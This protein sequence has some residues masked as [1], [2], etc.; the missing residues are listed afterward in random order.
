MKNVSK[1]ALF[2]AAGM[3]TAGAQAATIE[4]AEGTSME[5]EGAFTSDYLLRDTVD[6][7]VTGEKDN[8][9]DLAG[10]I[11]LS[12]SAV[13]SFD[14][15]DAY[16]EAAFLFANQ[17]TGGTGTEFDG[18]VAGLEGDF[19]QIEVG[20]TDSVYEDLITDSVDIT[21]EAGLSYGTYGFDENNMLT[22]Y[23]PETAGFSFRLQ[24]GIEDEVEGTADQSDQ[25]FIASA[26]YDFGAGAI[27]V[28]YDERGDT[29]GSDDSL[30]GIAAIFEV[31]MAEVSL[32]HEMETDASDQDTDYTGLAISYGY[33]AGKLYGAF[34]SESPDVG[35][36]K[37]QYAFGISA[38]LEDGINVYAEYADFDGQTGSDKDT[39]VAVGLAYEF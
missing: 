31:G 15:F 17:E 18:A 27:H 38:E 20:H 26:A 28:G 33:G 9:D 37:S 1:L 14:N 24:L 30:T 7:S 36:D 21:E 19:G 23:S 12:W 10:E 5:I 34:Q 2:V 3:M 11:E 25:G 29:A 13:R 35:E 22:Y 6:T 8:Q 16:T 32:A 4:I 39:L